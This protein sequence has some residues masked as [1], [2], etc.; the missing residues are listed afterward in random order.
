MPGGKKKSF[1]P[2]LPVPGIS[3][4]SWRLSRLS[5]SMAGWHY[6]EGLQ[7]WWKERGER[8]LGT[9]F[10]FFFLSSKNELYLTILQVR[11]GSQLAPRLSCCSSRV[12]CRL[13]KTQ[14]LLFQIVET[15]P[16]L[17]FF[18]KLLRLLAISFDKPMDNQLAKKLFFSLR[19][20][21]LSQTCLMQAKRLPCSKRTC[22]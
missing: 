20:K 11:Q 10:F 16:P 19:L 13:P 3:L 17:L 4:C 5:C 2:F 18:F 12:L 14:D 6:T 21:S 15:I 8:G 1:V 7:R 22:C 9:W